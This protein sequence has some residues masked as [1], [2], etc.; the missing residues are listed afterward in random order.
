MNAETSLKGTKDEINIGKCQLKDAQPR[1]QDQE[2]G[3]VVVPAR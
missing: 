2:I 1:Q 3:H